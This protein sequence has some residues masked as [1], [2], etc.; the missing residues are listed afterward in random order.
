MVRFDKNID[1]RDMPEGADRAPDAAPADFAKRGDRVA[2][3]LKTYAT[4]FVFDTFSEDFLKRGDVPFMRDVPIPLRE[5]D[6]EAF[7]SREGLPVARIEENM[8]RV[9][10]AAPSFPHTGAY[11]EFLRRGMG[12]R[13]AAGLIREAENA[14]EREEYD[15][16]CIGFRAA[17]CLE[18]QNLAAMYGYARVCRAM[19]LAG[20]DNERDGEYVGRFKAEALEYFELTTEAHPRFPEAHYYLGYAYL[21]LGLYQKARLAWER[22]LA[23]S[24]HP[25]DRSEIKERMRLLADPIEIERGCNAILA[26]RLAEGA[27]ALEPYLRSEYGDWWPLFHYLGVAYV[28]LHRRDEALDMFKRV[29]RLNPSHV[30][31]MKA[32]ADLYGADGNAELSEKYR[33]KA[34]LIESGGY[35]V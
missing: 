7:R 15:E 10:G 11:I 6:L 3:Y 27:A 22:Y 21:N 9:M 29:L 4:R 25:A 33:G 12:E 26:G 23:C 31:S 34:A 24:S 19:Y 30:E 17:L 1:D 16:A 5:G 35:I 32:L 2:R 13:A 14:A 20:K 8:A 28:G 18:P